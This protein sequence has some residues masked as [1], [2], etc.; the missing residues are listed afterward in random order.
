[1]KPELPLHIDS[2]M[3]ACSRSCMQKFYREF[4]LGLRT[5][6]KS[7][8]LHAGGCF[9]SA[10]EDVYRGLYEHNLSLDDALARAQL[11]FDRNWGDFIIPP[12]KMSGPGATAKTKERVWDA[13]YMDMPTAEERGYF[14][15]YPPQTDSIKPYF[16][17]NGR[18]T[19]EY[20][21]AIPLEPAVDPQTFST[22]DAMDDASWGQPSP[23]PLHPSG[24]P[25]T[26]VGRL[27]MLGARGGRPIW[28]DEKTTGTTPGANWAEKWRARS[29]F[30]GYTWACRQCGI[31]VI[32]GIVR[33]IGI[34]KTKIHHIESPLLD[35]SD[36]LIERWHEQLRRDLWKIRRAWD[37]GYWDYD[38]ADACTDYGSCIFLD[39]C[40]SRDP[41]MW[42]NNFVV[43]HWNPLSKNPIEEPTNV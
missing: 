18:P 28:R 33:G 19:F 5:P 29:Q 31:P 7:I 17:S 30:I 13:V 10:I 12:H 3:I 37:E 9:A 41:D 2:T 6:T 32:G 34:L 20:T 27:D 24:A 25:F 23:F 35:Y 22:A 40:T 21:F 15:A 43:S 4:V 1:M 42:N 11:F 16:D 36:A 14:N 26:Y 38:L 8:D 39:A